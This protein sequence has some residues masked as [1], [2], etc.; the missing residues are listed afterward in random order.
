MESRDSELIAAYLDG[1]L[2]ESEIGELRTRLHGDDAFAEELIEWAIDEARIV[3]WAASETTQPTEEKEVSPASLKFS[4]NSRRRSIL[5]GLSVAVSLLIVIVGTWWLNRP[6]AFAHITQVGSATGLSRWLDWRTIRAGR[7]LA[8]ASGVLEIETERGVRITL[9]GPCDCRFSSAQLVHLATGRLYADV[10]PAGRGFRVMTPNCTVDDW[11]TRFGVEVDGSTEVHV[12][13][14]R[15]TVEQSSGVGD[16]RNVTQGHAVVSEA[17][18]A[19]IREIPLN[20]KFA[21]GAT[22]YVEH[23]DYPRGALAGQRGWIDYDVHDREVS[24]EQQGLEYPSLAPGVGGSLTVNSLN[25]AASPIFR[26]W[27]HRFFSAIVQFDDDF[28][29]R[30]ARDHKQTTLLAFSADDLAAT[31]RVRVLTKAEGRESLVS[32]GIGYDQTEFAAQQLP[33][34]SL[35]LLVVELA[36]DSVRLW[37]DPD[38]KILGQRAPE[39]D[40]TIARPDSFQ[41][42][43][44]WI[45]D[46]DNAGYAWFWIDEIRGGNSWADV[47]PAVKPS[48]VNFNR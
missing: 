21:V 24:I 1:Q 23:F 17:A 22:R 6:A 38:K 40:A 45:G 4:G 19:E 43:W 14:G 9:E 29:K 16:K 47:T 10:P 7:T 36:D 34:Q 13:D 48:E 46:T 26:R 28:A 42:Q 18:D 11:G 12:F 27:H 35:H 30:M 41:P 15:V 2:S 31:P 25:R 32:F 39:P 8:L 33:H 5:A 20:R 3:D 37:V 44:I